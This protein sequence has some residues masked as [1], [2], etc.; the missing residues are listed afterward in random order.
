MLLPDRIALNKVRAHK[1]DYIELCYVWSG[2]CYQ[3]IEGKA[4]T[5]EKGDVCIFDTHAVHSIE[6]GRRR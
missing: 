6:V 5:T 3:T 1:H 4:V 2:I